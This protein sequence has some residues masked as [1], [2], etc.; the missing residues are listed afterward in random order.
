MISQATIDK[1]FET[2]R[3]E[4]VISD[5]VSLKK[6]GSSLKGLSPFSNEKTPSFMVSPAKQIFKDF[7]SNKGG[8][9]V[10]FLMEHEHYT[11]PEALRFLAKRYNI[12][13]EETGQSDE[14][15]QQRSERE[16]LF[17][18]N[19]YANKYFQKQLWESEKGKL[20]GHGYFKERGFNDQTIKEFQLG[21]S[22]NEYE[23]L[24]KA[25][26]KD[27]YQ[28]EFLEKSG[29]VKINGSNNTDRFRGRVM[30]P[31]L[32]HT[33]R[34]LGFGGRT[35]EANAKIAKYLNS[36]ESE[37]YH[38][39][40]TL[41]GIFQAKSEL[42]KKDECLLVEG[43]TDVISLHQASVKNV[44]ASSGTSLTVD[45]INLIKRFT[46]N[47]TILFDGD[48][49]GI[50]ASLR[51]I[52]M[53]LKEGMNVKVLLFPD[54]QDPDSF[55]KAHSSEDL[56]SFIS[57]EKKDFLQYKTQLLLTDAGDSPLEKSKVAREICKSIA[58]IP[59]ALEREA[60]VQEC[61]R[62]LKL[63]ERILFSE[64]AQM[65]KANF[66]DL[67]RESKR[68]EDREVRLNLIKD[69]NQP[70]LSSEEYLQE[71]AV[72]SLLLN[73]ANVMMPPEE[74]KEGEK[75]NVEFEEEKVGE[76]LILE[77]D[78][79]NISFYHKP[80]Q[81]VYETIKEHFNTTG[82]V[83]SS[84]QLIQNKNK[85]IVNVVADL[86][87]EKHQLNNWKK[88]KV[89]V[90]P[91][92]ELAP[93]FAIESQ[94]RLKQLRLSASIHEIKLKIRELETSGSSLELISSLNDLN[95]LKI[96]INERLNRVVG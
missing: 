22:P 12:E 21:Y 54:G 65:R 40:K 14:E 39:S 63:E 53:I 88:Q 26:L 79:D 28:L 71:K 17:L 91:L 67:E 62:L 80:Y 82:E 30:F 8:N 70:E 6:N 29:L 84:Q 34:V 76:Y 66:K 69:E 95:K 72:L 19:E 87:S 41:Y 37:I 11:Y 75:D 44:V 42:S 61:A 49:A 33:G 9:V 81:L 51:G 59:D 15:K 24:S 85:E 2:A 18:I 90:T 55:A 27:S 23:A 50:K 47:I 89:H 94:L 13:I 16:S 64:L 38:K 36:P 52:D 74:T 3:I 43:Y 77:L 58:V 20:I 57:A 35:L 93:R 60:Y 10:S 78:Q 48:A 5:F 25:A 7:S 46:N 96:K 31:I 4:E 92:E 73:F 56:E 45:Q 32:S 83:L 1:I 86:I 68:E